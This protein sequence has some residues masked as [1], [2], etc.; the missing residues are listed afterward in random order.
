VKL[1]AVMTRDV[2]VV[3]PQATLQEAAERMKSLNVG[4][5]PVCDGDRVLG[6]ITDRDITV[7]ATAAGQAPDSTK[8]NEVMTPDVIYAFDDQDV[9]EAA[10][11][12]AEHQIRR[13]LVLNRDMR[14][15]GIVSLG[16]VAVEAG[17]DRMTG[18]VL[19]QVSQPSQPNR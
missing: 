12:M 11:L 2:D 15:T 19:E 1:N 8:V 18:D 14:L 5:L 17:N 7:R 10:K 6:M 16:D 13:L 4:S 3:A 9:K